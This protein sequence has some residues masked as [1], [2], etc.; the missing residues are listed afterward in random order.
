MGGKNHQ[1]C[2][3]PGTSY[4][5]Y[6]TLMSRYLSVAYGTLEQANV[7]LEDAMLSEIEGKKSSLAEVVS[8]LLA[9]EHALY[10]AGISISA[11]RVDMGKNNYV[12]LPT[13]RTINLERLGIDLAKNDMVS[14]NAW[15]RVSLIMEE[16]GFYGVLNFFEAGV[17]ELVSTTRQLI[18]TMT[19]LEE[20]SKRCGILQVV[21]EN[22]HGNIKVD[23]ARLY[24]MWG[25]FNACFLAS[26]MLST[27]LWYAYMQ[28]C[29]LLEPMVAFSKIA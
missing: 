12:D 11:L 9:S 7:Y 10:D 22:R 20:I 25:N 18:R 16:S 29:S 17:N 3:K 1:P 5:K 21:E 2:N 15:G 6:S 24:T 14:I 27:E 8:S 26:S 13:L 28:K 19:Y 4:L 23:F